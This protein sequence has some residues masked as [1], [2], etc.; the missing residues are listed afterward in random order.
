[1]PR[2]APPAGAQKSQVPFTLSSHLRDKL[3]R[4][5]IMRYATFA[6]LL[7]ATS[8]ASAADKVIG[9]PFVVNATSRSATV[10]WVVQS[11]EVTAKSQDGSE[12]HTAG[13]LHAE[14]VTLTGL[15]A[16]TAYN[17]AVPGKESLKGTFKTPPRGG[18]PSFEFVVYGDTRT[19]HDVHRTVVAAIE[20]YAHPDFL[21]HTGDLVENGGDPSLWP[22]FFDIEGELLRTCA[23]YPALG[24]HERH[25]R[26]YGDFMQA[27]PYY[28][29]DWGSAHFSIL[30]S[31]IGTAAATD[32]AKQ[33]Y[34][35]EQ[36]EWLEA[37]LKKNQGSL[38]R[39]VVAHHPPMTAVSSRQGDNRHMTELM[40]MLEQY[41]VTAALFGHDHNY[42][43]YLKNGIHY[44]V[45]GG[46]G[47][48]L[49]D[50]KMPPADITVKVMSTENFVRI[51]IEG[52][53]A[54]AQ[55]FKPDGTTIDEF[56]FQGKAGQ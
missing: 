44:V 29:F 38:F 33:A 45:T 6:L 14:S 30:D 12:T 9:G 42:Q 36:R 8:V 7:A 3:E 16:G 10:V 28:S 54:T 11:D 46:G 35:K 22:I 15:K 32:A 4:K 41:H 2:R 20:K 5:P 43:H 19:R 34:W 24:N 53:R 39:F 23:L 48:P 55:A 18:T 52:D 13:A 17:Y 25:A 47:A 56:T 31:D 50:V 26:D 51:R 21:L 27:P 49:Y 40:P 1:M 37:D